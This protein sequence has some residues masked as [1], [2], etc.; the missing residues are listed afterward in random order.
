MSTIT[1]ALFCV[2]AGSATA[3]V[4]VSEQVL[5]S[6]QYAK[7]SC[8]PDPKDPDY[9]ECI[10]DADVR[11]PQLSGISDRDAQDRLNRWFKDEAG[12][13][14]CDGDKMAPSAKNASAPAKAHMSISV[15][16]ETTYSSDA[17]LALKFTDWAYTGG[18]HGNGSVIGVIADLAQGKLLSPGDMFSEKNTEIANR[19]IYEALSAKP[20][21]EVFRD[22]I[23]S[24]K[25]AFIKDGECQG[26]TLTLTP[27][28]VHV[29]FQTYEVAPYGAGNTDVIIPAKYI[30]YA[31]VSKALKEH[32][33]EPEKN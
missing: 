29:L 23:E 24:R 25:G 3:A 15:H 12:K 19:V 21:G 17:I 9:D 2:W 30:S 4:T 28:G 5:Q 33:R 11:Y 16:Y 6:G 14:V 13:A 20:E 32:K 18:A 22:Q 26:C 31:A 7:A 8:K 10:C 1:A 27:E